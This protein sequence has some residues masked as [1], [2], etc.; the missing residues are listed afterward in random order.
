MNMLVYNM[1]IVDGENEIYK[2]RIED[3]CT[4]AYIEFNLQTRELKYLSQNGIID[5]LKENEYQLRKI[6]H[7]KRKNTFYK[8][9]K[10]KF[11]LRD[12]KDVA[13]FNDRSKIVV[14]DKRNDRNDS[15]VVEHGEDKIYKVYTDGCFLE[16]KGKGGYTVLIKDLEGRY[17]IHTLR[18]KEKSSSLI[19]LQAAIKAMDILTNI[20]K[21]RIITDS[22]YVRKGLTEW[23]LNWRL[24]NWC[25]IN[26]N[27]VKNIEYWKQFDEL[28]NGKYIEFEWVK[29]HS[30]HFENTI[31]DLYAREIAEKQD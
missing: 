31:C 2:I 20:E 15:Y 22:Q 26:G 28:T 30:E 24:N 5:V 8:G 25:T 16:E 23:I 12:K 3:L 27:K 14:L 7:N 6:L 19:E 10:L 13:A 18:T 9:F 29:A 17:D 4:Y 11:A 1:E 21:V